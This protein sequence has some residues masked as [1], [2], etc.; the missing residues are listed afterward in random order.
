C[1]EKDDTHEGKMGEL[2]GDCHNPNAWML[3]TFNHDEQTEF[4]LDGKHGEVFCHA[5]HRAEL[6]EHKQSA[7]HCYGCHRGDDI[8]RGGFGRHCDRCHSTET[9]ENPEIR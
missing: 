7:N 5:C 6:T 4:P 3:W 1:H 2:C 9:F 8:H